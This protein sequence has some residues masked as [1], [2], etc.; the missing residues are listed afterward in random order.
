MKRQQTEKGSALLPTDDC[1]QAWW[2]NRSFRQERNVFE[3]LPEMYEKNIFSHILEKILFF[4]P[5]MLLSPLM[6]HK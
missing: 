6:H 1:P 4:R 3:R 5:F 2:Y